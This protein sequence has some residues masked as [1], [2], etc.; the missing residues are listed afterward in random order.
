M[1]FR[2]LISNLGVIGT[3]GNAS[4]V[5]NGWSIILRHVIQIH[6]KAEILFIFIVAIA[7]NLMPIIYLRIKVSC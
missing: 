3:A 6:S 4:P 1:V 2:Y 7:V 5:M